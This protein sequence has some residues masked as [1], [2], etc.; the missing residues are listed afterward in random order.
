MPS[1]FMVPPAR[2]SFFGLHLGR[3]YFSLRRAS[4]PSV[5]SPLAWPG[6]R[7]RGSQM[8]VTVA[9]HSSAAVIS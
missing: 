7:A 4:V 6:C 2:S 3:T 8:G 5:T 9:G 1:F